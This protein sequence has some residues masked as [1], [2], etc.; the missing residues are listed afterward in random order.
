MKNTILGLMLVGSMAVGGVMWSGSESEAPPVVGYISAEGAATS[1]FQVPVRYPVGTKLSIAWDSYTAQQITDSGANRYEVEITGAATHAATL[2]I[3]ATTYALPTLAKGD[4]TVAVRG[5]NPTACSAPA[6]I[7][8]TL[9]PVTPTT[10]GN[11]RLI[12]D[13]TPVTVDQAADMAHAYAV[14]VAGR[15]LTAEELSFLASNYR[16]PMTRGAVK[17]YL[18]ANYLQLF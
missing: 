5:C 16:G 1:G 10:P 12:P 8:F 15:R 9:D 3:T 7:S 13:A 11:L 18:D 14:L 2:A 17:E 4:Y 6:S